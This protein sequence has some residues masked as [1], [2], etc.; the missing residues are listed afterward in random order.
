ME[1]AKTETPRRLSLLHVCLFSSCC[2][3]AIIGYLSLEPE[4]F[5]DVGDLTIRLSVLVALGI[6]AAI[7]W[8]A[9]RSAGSRLARRAFAIA[10]SSL[11]LLGGA[12]AYANYA[13]ASVD[14]ASIVA[15]RQGTT[16]TSIALGPD[17]ED[18]RLSGDLTE[19][20][21]ARLD[22]V[23]DVNPQVTRI[24]LT[25]EGGLAE[26]GRALAEVIAGHDLTTFV[27]DFCV[28]A[29]TLAFVGGRE[30]FLMKNSRLGFHAPYA[31]GFFG[32]LFQ[33]DSAVEREAYVDAGVSPGFVDKALKVASSEMWFP[34]ADALIGAGV[35]TGV[36]DRYRFPDSNLDGAPTLAG[37]RAA[38]ARSFPIVMAL[39]AHRHRTLETAAAWYLDAYR[40]GLS[41]GL[42]ADSLKA[43]IGREVI[44]ALA[45]ADDQTLYGLARY[46][47]RAMKTV[48]HGAPERC[49]EIGE[50]ADLVAAVYLLGRTQADHSDGADEATALVTRA[51]QKAP[52]ADE[53]TVGRSV[54]VSKPSTAACQDVISAYDE[55]VRMSAG[56]AASE[57]RSLLKAH[58]HVAAGT[59]STIAESAR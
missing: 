58:M 50:N 57:I 4:W 42:V 27:P 16:E 36:V 20:A 5:D 3:I 38:I 39:E 29:C 34:S 21:A 2:L 28:S 15:E 24:H 9:I 11:I 46:L 22:A 45:Q 56:D 10:A 51:L 18:V 54:N 12:F 44:G 52:D 59:L 30:R 40:R 14:L 13:D 33:G 43:M 35:V 8:R 31:E 48:G 37:A 53:V 41:E 7:A 17:R 32:E 26:E 49:V 19:G 55:L 6:G 1:Q 47:A 25:S 23:L